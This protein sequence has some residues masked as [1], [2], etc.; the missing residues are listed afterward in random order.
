MSVYDDFNIDRQP[1]KRSRILRT[2][3]WGVLIFIGCV[4]I[5]VFIGIVEH[6][7]QKF[8]AELHSTEGEYVGTAEGTMY[9]L[10]PD[11]TMRIEDTWHK[12]LM[13]EEI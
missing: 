3:V 9:F 12:K 6:T 1:S 2:V 4:S 11:G 13:E 10:M 8:S 7:L 5:G